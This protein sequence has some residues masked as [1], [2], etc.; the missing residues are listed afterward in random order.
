MPSE[1]ALPPKDTP[2]ALHPRSRSR[3]RAASAARLAVTAVTATRRARQADAM[4]MHEILLVAATALDLIFSSSPSVHFIFVES[5][6]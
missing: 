5:V 6:D 2:A 4:A 3:P 1:T